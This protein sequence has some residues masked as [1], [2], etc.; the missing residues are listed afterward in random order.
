MT[1]VPLRPLARILEARASGGDPNAIE[2]ENK[3]LRHE[4]MRDRA[5]LRAEGRDRKSVV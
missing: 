4:E 5:R 3:R 2:R 1:R